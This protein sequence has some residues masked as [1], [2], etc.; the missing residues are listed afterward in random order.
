MERGRRGRRDVRGSDLVF[1]NHVCCLANNQ[2]GPSL[3]RSRA[4]CEWTRRDWYPVSHTISRA[5]LGKRSLRP[6]LTRNFLDGKM[7][8]EYETASRFPRIILR[9]VLSISVLGFGK[10]RRAKCQS[11]R[12]ISLAVGMAAESSEFLFSEKVTI[13]RWYR[14]P[15]YVPSSFCYRSST[16]IFNDSSRRENDCFF[17]LFPLSGKFR[18]SR[19]CVNDPIE[20]ALISASRRA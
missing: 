14:T 12:L 11:K 5:I 15:R 10:A 7:R 16:W 4:S 9:A 6:W 17:D 8:K 2:N 13:S 18:V 20:S 1:V 19:G 3:L